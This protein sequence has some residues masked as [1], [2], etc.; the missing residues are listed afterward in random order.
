MSRARKSKTLRPKS[1][2]SA[3]DGKSPAE[4]IH[5]PG[6]ALRPGSSPVRASD[7]VLDVAKKYARL[8]A[9]GDDLASQTSDNNRET[10][11]LEEWLLEQMGDDVQNLN[12][13]VDVP[14]ENGGVR[15]R[16]FTIYQRSDSNVWKA[17]GVEAAD[18]IAALRAVGWAEICSETYNAATLKATVREMR[19]RF[20]EGVDAD[21]EGATFY[22]RACDQFT[23]EP[24]VEN[25]ETT[26][27]AV[28]FCECGSALPLVEMVDGLPK[29]LVE[30]LFVEDVKRLG[31]RRA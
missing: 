13:S 16:S 4:E 7:T 19:R 20:A 11:L 17:K 10:A 30:V 28:N 15:V 29:R 8:R 3:G 31:C 21:A 26:G 5:K 12:V 23:S 14:D 2:G 9:H 18:L 25:D 24:V 6:A 22:C 27:E 1:A